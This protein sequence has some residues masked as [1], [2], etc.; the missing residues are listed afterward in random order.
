MNV[1][2][3]SEQIHVPPAAES[4]TA[5]PPSRSGPLEDRDWYA[6]SRE[7]AQGLVVQEFVETLPA[8]LLDF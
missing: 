3:F 5:T 2:R 7:L 8:D 6:S 1:P 4:K